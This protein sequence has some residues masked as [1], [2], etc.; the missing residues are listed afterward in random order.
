[1]IRIKESEL[2]EMIA[3][4]VKEELNKPYVY[5]FW[6]KLEKF[7]VT[8]GLTMT[9][10]AR[11]TI[12]ILK[13]KYDFGKLAAQFEC[14]NDSPMQSTME[15]TPRNCKTTRDSDKWYHIG[16]YFKFGIKDNV[17]TINDII[18]T[19]DACGWFLSDCTYYLRNGMTQNINVKNNKSVNFND[20]ELKNTPFKILFRAKFN[21]EYKPQTVPPFL[22][23]ICPLRVVDKILMQGLTPRN[24][25]RI[26]SHPERVYLFLDYNKEWRNIAKNFKFS[27]KNEPY[28]YLKIDTRKLN[29]Q[30]KFYYDSNTM[31]GCPAIYTLEPIPPT[32]IEVIDNQE[33]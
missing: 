2:R 12:Q 18:H 15:T 14:L 30:V 7:Y 19:C 24:N 3:E 6:N 10:G 21:A 25:G 9:Y 17:K 33:N 26:A 31:S 22:Y 28:V 29:P 4:R 23:H 5:E 16:I 27:G 32:A 1:M 13:N 20:E 8:E 11:K